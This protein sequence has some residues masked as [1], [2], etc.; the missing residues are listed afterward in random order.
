MRRNIKQLKDFPAEE[1]Q[2][3]RDEVADWWVGNAYLVFVEDE[4]ASHIE[5]KQKSLILNKSLLFAGKIKTGELDGC[6]TVWQ[7]IYVIL[8]GECIAL[9]P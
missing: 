8:T 9:L 5:L 4:Y 3:A 7:R 2:K 1:V 6:F